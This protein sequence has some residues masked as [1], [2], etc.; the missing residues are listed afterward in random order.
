MSF[1]DFL[2]DAARSGGNTSLEPARVIHLTPLT[3]SIAG[4]TATAAGVKRLGS[5]SP[6]VGDTIAVLRSGSTLLVLGVMV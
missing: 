5:Y 1:A 3:I 6:H 4:A 2:A